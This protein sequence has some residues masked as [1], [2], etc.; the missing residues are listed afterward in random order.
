MLKNVLKCQ[1][2]G[3]SITLCLSST[4]KCQLQTAYCHACNKLDSFNFMVF[5]CSL[6]MNAGFALSLCFTYEVRTSSTILLA[7]PASSIRAN[8]V[9]RQ[10]FLFSSRCSNLSK[11]KHSFIVSSPNFKCQ[12]SSPISSS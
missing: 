9:L 11:S 5:A 7:F 4:R 10:S 8:R 3:T 6:S 1:C 12:C 2:E